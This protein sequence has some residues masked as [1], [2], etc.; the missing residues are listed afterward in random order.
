MR[1]IRCSSLPRYAMCPGALT[2][3]DGLKSEDSAVSLAGT[4]GHGALERYYDRYQ[5]F[6]RYD[7]VEVGLRPSISEFL[8]GLD[9][10]T[11]SRARWYAHVM[12]GAIE[13]HG[14]AVEIHT[15]V[16]MSMVLSV[17]R[18]IGH[19]DLTV[20]CADG[21]TLI[22]DWK[23]N[24]LEVPEA[25][26]NI[27]LM[28]YALLAIRDETV[29]ADIPGEIHTILI[30][31]GN[32]NPFTA[33]KYTPASTIAL[34]TYIKSIVAGSL[35]DDAKRVP[36][37][38]ACKYCTASGT[39][40]CPERL[41]EIGNVP[42]LAMPYEILP[43]PDK[44]L[45]LFK[46]VKMVETFGRK[47]MSD[48]KAAVTENPEAWADVFELSNTGNTRTIKD[49]QDAY[50]IFVTDNGLVTHE[51]FMETMKVAIGKLEKACKPVMK[52][53]SIPVKDQKMMIARLL[54]N[55]LELKEKAKSLKVVKS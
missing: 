35:A 41:E 1:K 26:H 31:G 50:N 48:V 6:L 44:C 5:E 45:E 21:V 49:A 9:D 16:A 27:Q 23:F 51:E 4:E 53:R 19:N 15:E 33:A 11:A 18:L 34:E 13:E 7:P 42:A 14:G 54:G 10:M 37:D 8:D 28:G 47:F 17:V 43:N 12:D 25:A 24:F 32:E 2:A 29:L 30:A 52:E 36:N 46:A 3:E 39:T 22:S 40:R 38:D 55:N 20:I